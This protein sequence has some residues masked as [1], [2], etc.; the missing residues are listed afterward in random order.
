MSLFSETLDLQFR[1]VFSVTVLKYL[2]IQTNIYIFYYKISF[3]TIHIIQEYLKAQ[4]I[5][6]SLI[7]SASAETR[8]AVGMSMLFSSRWRCSQDWH[9][10]EVMAST[11]RMFPCWL[12]NKWLS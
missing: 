7:S 12:R 10:Q 1:E 9:T 8:A 5:I 3:S 6:I 4:S 2:H 11:V